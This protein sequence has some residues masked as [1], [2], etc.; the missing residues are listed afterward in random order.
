MSD[1]IKLVLSDAKHEN[2]L[3]REGIPGRKR[4]YAFMEAN[5]WFGVDDVANLRTFTMDSEPMDVAEDYYSKI[6]DRVVLWLRAYG[7][8]H[9]E[10]YRLLTDYARKERPETVK[11]YDVFARRRGIT[12]DAAGWQLL[13]FILSETEKEIIDSDDD[14][15]NRLVELAATQI[16]GEQLQH[17]SQF[18]Q[19]IQKKRSGNLISIKV[20]RK[21]REKAVQEAY[22]LE[23]FSRMAY[24]I[25]NEDSWAKESLVEKACADQDMANLWVF[26]AFHF[27]CGLRSTDIVRIPKPLL[28]GSGKEIQ[29]QILSGDTRDFGIY[30]REIQLQMDFKPYVPGKTERFGAVPDVKVFIPL[31]LEKSMGVIIAL[32]ASHHDEI[33]AGEPFIKAD[34]Y[35]SRTHRFFGDEF[36]D[37]M[38]GKAFS[39]KRA[40][41]S[42]LQGLELATGL[43]GE[44]APRGYMIAALARSHKGGLGKMPDVTDAYLRDAKFTGL[45]PEFVM[46]EMFE[47]GVFGFIPHMLMESI[48]G[49]DYAKL[50]VEAQTELIREIG[51]SA[52][53]LEKL[54]Q[55]RDSA[56]H[57]A[58]EAVKGALEYEAPS[59]IIRKIVDGSSAGMDRAGL[60]IMIA[61]GAGCRCLERSGCY[62]CR[63]EIHTKAQMHKLMKEYRR[64]RN[65]SVNA[66]GW[67]Y[68]KIAK[69]L[70]IPVISEYT[71][72]LENSFDADMQSLA[73]IMRGEAYDDHS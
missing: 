25:F 50:P 36:F 22:T 6:R 68:R 70:L 24:I 48:Y 7:K 53:S 58:E 52:E 4:L 15:I 56:L 39:T 18:M 40:N 26:V 63:Y 42:Y 62:G 10:K 29:E 47:R 8:S 35:V 31:S 33:P 14:E 12:G 51:L 67:R 32:A 27:V 20:K 66:D 17:F 60:C 69:E 19:F 65:C 5:E 59:T 61:A 30:A 71:W 57:R 23:E 54:T 49:N 1:F 16:A 64:L 45:S 28:H 13:D 11:E 44:N 37:E 41:K 55:M 46:R 2:S 3:F 43:R 72:C 9:S 21:K 34:R 38:G 73:E